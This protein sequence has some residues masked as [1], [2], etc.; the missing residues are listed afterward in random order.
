MQIMGAIFTRIFKAF[1][2][3]VSKSKLFGVR[4]Q[5]LHTH[6]QHHCFWW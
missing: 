5:P 6:H 1:A 3:I 2:Q 4:L